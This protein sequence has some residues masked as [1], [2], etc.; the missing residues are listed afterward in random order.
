MRVCGW[1]I[2]LNMKNLGTVV[3]LIFFVRRFF[4]STTCDCKWIAFKALGRHYSFIYWWSIN[5]PHI[6]VMGF[7]NQT[8]LKALC[9]F[10]IHEWI[11]RWWKTDLCELLRRVTIH[12]Y[13]IKTPSEC[14]ANPIW[15]LFLSVFSAYVFL[16]DGLQIASHAIAYEL[17]LH[18]DNFF[19]EWKL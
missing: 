14:L 5:E 13:E 6:Q 16:Q 10:V 9:A 12:F 15:Q 3:G 11:L 17:V 1:E 8:R 2:R 7:R 18:V 4:W 19:F